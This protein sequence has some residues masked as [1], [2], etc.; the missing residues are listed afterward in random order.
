MPPLTAKEGNLHIHMCK[1][2][3]EE[4]AEGKPEQSEGRWRWGG[5]EQRKMFFVVK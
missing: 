3:V 1:E 2:Q 5:G 4:E